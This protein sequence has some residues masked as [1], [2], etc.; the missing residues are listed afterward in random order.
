MK[1]VFMTKQGWLILLASCVFIIG[2]FVLLYRFVSK[3]SASLVEDAR[4]RELSDRYLDNVAK[5]GRLKGLANAVQELRKRPGK[6][7]AISNESVDELTLPKDEKKESLSIVSQR[8]QENHKGGMD[9]NSKSS[10]I[11]QTP[12]HK[13]PIMSLK[14]DIVLPSTEAADEIVAPILVIAC[15]RP[16]A[17]KRCLDL[18]LQHRPSAKQFPIIVSQDCGHQETADVIASH[19]SKVTHIKQPDLSEVQGAQHH[20]MGYY[21]IS[22]HYKWALGQAFDSM[23]HDT[24]IIVEDDLDIGEF[25]NIRN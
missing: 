1:V 17:V 19:G 2:N 23:G 16:T 10:V 12:D 8:V 11:K 13:Q 20:M 7:T 5:K 3:T 24:V 14:K 22:R 9:T 4:L 18:L 25:C 6:S 21:K 15:N